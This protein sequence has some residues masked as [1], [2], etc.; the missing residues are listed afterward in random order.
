M[1]ELVDLCE[2]RAAH[3]ARRER[4]TPQF[5]ASQLAETTERVLGE[6]PFV[7]QADAASA[8]FTLAVLLRIG[9]FAVQ[10]S[11]PR[12]CQEAGKLHVRSLDKSVAAMYL[13][14]QGVHDLGK[15]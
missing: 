11:P 5:P 15:T 7:Q 1:V 9:S 6:H 14:K 3:Q 13:Q 10:S 12:P 2:G 8:H 4:R